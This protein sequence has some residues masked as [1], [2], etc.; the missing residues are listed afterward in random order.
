MEER[1]VREGRRRSRTVG[2]GWEVGRSNWIAPFAV[3]NSAHKSS[4]VLG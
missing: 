1:R 2:T 4:Q 3:D